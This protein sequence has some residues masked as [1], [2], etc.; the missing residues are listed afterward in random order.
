MTPG[1]AAVFAA[2][3]EPY[4]NID[5]IVDIERE[6]G[7]PTYYL[8]GLP[9]EASVLTSGPGGAAAQTLKSVLGSLASLATAFPTINSIE[10][11]AFKNTALAAA[12]YMLA[13]A[14][15]GLATSPMEGFDACRVRAAC[16]IPSR[17]GIPLVIATG[18]PAA[19]SSDE[20]MASSPLSPRL[21]PEKVFRLDTFDQ[22]YD[23]IT[24]PEAEL[25]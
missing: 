2:D 4:S 6:A 8:Q 22:G 1:N 9:F 15:A 25:R 5:E 7:K 24:Q 19:V 16:R 18:Y 21:S 20:Q 23:G 10:G 14:A 11:W 17:Y 13:A 3:L 12:T